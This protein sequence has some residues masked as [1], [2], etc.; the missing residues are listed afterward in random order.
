MFNEI[1]EKPELLARILVIGI[2]AVIIFF[3]FNYYYNLVS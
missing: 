3:D 2:I 1:S